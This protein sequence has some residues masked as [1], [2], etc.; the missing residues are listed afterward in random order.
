MKAKKIWIATHPTQLENVEVRT[1]E[2]S[3]TDKEVYID[4]YLHTEEG[5]YCEFKEY[6]LIEVDAD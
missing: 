5:S 4:S 2:P 1:T 6:I 3:Y